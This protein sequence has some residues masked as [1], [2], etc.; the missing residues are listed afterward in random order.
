MTLYIDSNEPNQIRSKVQNEI[1]NRD[2]TLATETQG[3]KTGDFVIGNTCIERKEASDLAS[4]IKDGR[5]KSQSERISQDFQK[6]YI[7]IEGDPYNLTY[8]NLH[9]NAVTGTQVSRSEQGM[10]IISVPNQ[11]G[12]AYAVYKICQKHL[13]E[14]TQTRKLETTRAE[15]QYTLTAMLTCIHGISQSKAEKIQKHYTTMKQLVDDPEPE[16]TLTQIQGIGDK[17]S[18][19]IINAVKH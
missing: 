10:H 11:D 4:S 12:T 16:T 8:S 9:P 5:L 3:L 19:R 15:T 18:E 1:Q 17:T 14:T 13:S 2:I 6:G 7:L